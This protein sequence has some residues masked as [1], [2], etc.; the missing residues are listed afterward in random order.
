MAGVDGEGGAL[1]YV[2]TTPEQ[3]EEKYYIL[4][5]HTGKVLWSFVKKCYT[6]NVY[7]RSIWVFGLKV[8]AQISLDSLNLLMICTIEGEIP[9]ILSITCCGTL[10]QN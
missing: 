4:I 5:I 2:T 8:Y 10:F 7:D 9:K 6:C 3:K 1:R